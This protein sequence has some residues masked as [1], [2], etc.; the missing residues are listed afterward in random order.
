MPRKKKKDGG[1]DMEDVSWKCWRM[2]VCV[3][4]W[5]KWFKEIGYE[6]EGYGKNR[7]NI[8]SNYPKL[9]KREYVGPRNI[10]SSRVYKC[11]FRYVATRC[12]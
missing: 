7:K 8:L 4:K 10:N 2:A 9:L 12:E 3:E 11:I 1:K 5:E 6:G